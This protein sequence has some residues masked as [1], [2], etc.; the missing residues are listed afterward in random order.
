MLGQKTLWQRERK[1][2]ISLDMQETVATVY[3]RRKINFSSP[4]A[5]S[6]PG[7][8]IHLRNPMP[9]ILWVRCHLQASCTFRLPDHC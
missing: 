8:I 2:R 3:R 4:R 6:Y 7:M 1:A 9:T 5:H